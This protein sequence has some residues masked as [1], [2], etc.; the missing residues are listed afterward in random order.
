MIEINLLPGARK[1]KRSR[2]AAFDFGA[3]FGN[4]AARVR[5]PFLIAAVVCVVIALVAVGGMFLYQNRKMD[6]L[7]EHSAK[8]TQDSTR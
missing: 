4:L 8:A 5:D 3:F 7:T 6:S 2:S 1:Q